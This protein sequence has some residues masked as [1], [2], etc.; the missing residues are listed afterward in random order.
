MYLVGRAGPAVV[1]QLPVLPPPCLSRCYDHPR[2]VPRSPHPPPARLAQSGVL[3]RGGSVQGDGADLRDLPRM[4]AL[5]VAVRS[6]PDALRSRRREQDDGGR[7][8]REIGLR[9]GRR[10][11][12]SLRP[13]L[14]DQVPVRSAASVERGFPASHA[15]GEGEE[16][17]RR[18]HVASRSD[19]DQHGQARKARHDPGGGRVREQAQSRSPPTRCAA[20]CRSSSLGIS[21]G[22]RS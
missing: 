14:H 10:P 12:L 3:R 1:T 16:V 15:A 18:R 4:P 6:F 11:V 2:R 19:A 21:S 9:E 17:P 8:R 20:A 5:R 7:R 22:S 13:V